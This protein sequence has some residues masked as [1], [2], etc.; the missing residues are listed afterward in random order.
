MTLTHRLSMAGYET[1]AQVLGYAVWQLAR[2]PDIQNALREE[3]ACVHSTN[4][5]DLQTKY[6][7][8]DA[9]CR[10]RSVA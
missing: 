1:T 8:L 10:E 7:L 9:V 2:H 4:I 3:V 5:D 6:P